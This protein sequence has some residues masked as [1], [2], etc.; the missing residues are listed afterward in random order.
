MRQNKKNFPSNFQGMRSRL[1]AIICEQIPEK[2]RFGWLEDQT[3][4]ARNTWQSLWNR[5]TAVPSGEMIQAVGRLFPQYAFWLATGLTDQEFG[6]TYPYHGLGKSFPEE[7]VHEERKRFND[8][9]QHIMQMQM[10][11][12]DSE[13]EM[14]DP[15]GQRAAREQLEYLSCLR[16]IELDMLREGKIDAVKKYLKERNDKLKQIDLDKSKN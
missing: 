11:V 14:H 3:G 1:F 4:I 9:F 15:E 2:G 8:Y 6:H 5:E 12:Y 10:N 16:E 7:R 13:T